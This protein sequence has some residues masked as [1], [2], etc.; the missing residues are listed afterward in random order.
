MENIGVAV[1]IVYD[2]AEEDVDN[3]IMSDDGTGGGI[4]IPSMLIGKTDG[5]KLIDFLKRASD[6]ELDQT[7]IMAQ[8]IMEK[9]DNRVEYDLWFTSSNDR[10]LDF[11]SD[12]KEYDRNFGNK[13]L[14]TPHYVFWKCNFCEEE[15]LKNDCFGGGKYC[16]VEP[17]NENIKGRD[18]ILEDL[19]EKCLYKKAY[20]S[21]GT[22]YVW[23]S[24]MEY[25]HQNCY[26]VINEECSSRAHQRLG[27]DFDETN[28]CVKESFTASN[29]SD[30]NTNNTMIDEEI[31]YW[32]TYG[33]GIYPA[34][35]IN[36]RTYRG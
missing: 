22:R 4:R 6:Q 3:V 1:A 20:Q 15:Y 28:K 12:F 13:V 18:I 7:A 29:W 26:N 19:R 34:I 16:A 9:P 21:P 23:W 17:S 5:K 35:V 31:A 30:P 2:D 36:N 27:L 14:M 10:A 33:S 8:F 11:I 25:V 32:K 24:Y